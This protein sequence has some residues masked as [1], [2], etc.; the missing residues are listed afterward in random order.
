M[1]LTTCCSVVQRAHCNDLITRLDI[2]NDLQCMRCS[3]LQWA[4]S[5]WNCQQY[6]TRRWNWPSVVVRR[7]LHVAVCCSV[8][9]CVAVWCSVLQCVAVHCSVLRLISCAIS[10]GNIYFYEGTA[11]CQQF[12]QCV[13]VCCSVLQHTVLQCLWVCWSV[14]CSL[15]TARSLGATPWFYFG[16]TSVFGDCEDVQWL[17]EDTSVGCPLESAHELRRVVCLLL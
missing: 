13:A 17:Q 10:V 16:T 3:V 14:C 7:I 5:T 9:P 2:F 1:K 4:C 12:L 6:T 8:L 11:C 15:H